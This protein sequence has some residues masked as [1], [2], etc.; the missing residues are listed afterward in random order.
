MKIPEFNTLQM[1]RTNPAHTGTAKLSDIAG[2]PFND[3][4]S[5][6]EKSAAKT[7]LNFEDY[8]LNAMNSMNSQ[9]TD[10]TNLEQQVLT[11]P[12]SVDPQDVT[13]AMAKARMSFNLA[14]T[15]IDRIV[16]G[17]N[18]ITTTR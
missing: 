1:T 13:V 5:A 4:P 2:A 7:Q 3:I 8:L 11:N 9:Q 16:T 12:D 15:V 18:E 17:W 6:A 10:V 14:Q